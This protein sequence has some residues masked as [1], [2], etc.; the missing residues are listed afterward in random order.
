MQVVMTSKVKFVSA[1][2][3]HL[4]TF[5]WIRLW[6]SLSSR[7]CGWVPIFWQH[8]LYLL[9][10]PLEGASVMIE[11]MRSLSLALVALFSLPG[12]LCVRVY[13]APTP[14]VLVCPSL[15]P[16]MYRLK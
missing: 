6:F 8:S 11:R 13:P 7:S 4:L 14:P 10:L 15:F 16:I 12:K 1:F 3:V 9:Y 2:G 5:F